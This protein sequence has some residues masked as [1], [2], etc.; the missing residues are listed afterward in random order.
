ANNSTFNVAAGNV[1][2]FNVGRMIGSRLQIGAHPPA[3]G[4]LLA[5]ATAANWNTPAAGFTFKLV[6]FK[7]TGIF[8]PTDVADSANFRDSFIVAQQLGTVTITGLDTTLPTTSATFRF[9]VGFRASAVVGAAPKITVSFSNG[10]AL[11]TQILSA[12]NSTTPASPFE[13]I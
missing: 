5:T 1:N 13:F 8:D 6:S 7:T 2:S 10:G 11:K 9:G 12:P 4:N 3:L